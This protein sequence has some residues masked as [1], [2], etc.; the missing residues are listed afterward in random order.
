MQRCK[1]L[2]W[3]RN[4]SARSYSTT[5]NATMRNLVQPYG[6]KV[7]FSVTSFVFPRKIPD[8]SETGW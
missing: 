1:M 6:I 5:G 7:M 3:F 8:L 4:A 2:L